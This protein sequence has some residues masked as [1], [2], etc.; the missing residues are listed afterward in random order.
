MASTLA[1]FVSAS[2]AFGTDSITPGVRFA[3]LECA[4]MAVVIGEFGLSQALGRLAWTSQ[5]PALRFGAISLA[6][7]A[8]AVGVCWGLAVL[9]EGPRGAPAVSQFVLPALTCLSTIAAVAHLR[10]RPMAAEAHPPGAR[11]EFMA[12]LPHR[13][14]AAT[15]IAVQG[16]DHYVRIHTSQG[17]HMLLMRLGDALRQL[18]VLEGAQTHRS[19]WVA[20]SAVTD[21]RRSSGRASLSLA[22]GLEVP[23]SRRFSRQLRVSGWY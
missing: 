15:I 2:G 16:E 14:R 11:P 21:V 6:T 3:V 1:A 4:A 17:D 13:L 8:G 7:L 22:N 23:V 19:W 12:R 5:R 9:M 18:A 10:K 20:K